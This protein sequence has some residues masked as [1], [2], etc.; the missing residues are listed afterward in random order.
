VKEQIYTLKVTGNKRKLIYDKTLQGDIL[1]DKLV[2]TSPFIIDENKNIIRS[3][4]FINY[5]T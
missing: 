5:N 4:L 3:H 1:V 2:D